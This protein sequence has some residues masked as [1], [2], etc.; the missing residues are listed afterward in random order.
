M[1]SNTINAW[2]IKKTGGAKILNN[3]YAIF[4]LLEK[5]WERELVQDKLIWLKKQR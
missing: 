1:N 4:Y 3:G 5:G 2:I